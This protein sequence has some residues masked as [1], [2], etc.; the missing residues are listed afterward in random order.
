MTELKVGPATLGD[1][2]LSSS[3]LSF[4]PHGLKLFI[5]AHASISVPSTLKWRFDNSRLTQGC[6]NT[7]ARNLTANVPFSSR[8][9]FAD[10]LE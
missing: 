2:P 5:D 7:A 8:S 1:P 4:G 10:K 3:P 9:Q 6:S